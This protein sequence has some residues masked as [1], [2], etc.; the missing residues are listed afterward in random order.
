MSG[1]CSV[2]IL[3]PPSESKTSGGRHW[4]L[5]QLNKHSQVIYE[6][7]TSYHGDLTQ[8]YGV[9]DKALEAART[10]NK[11]ILTSPTLP[12]I[13]RY[14]GVV[15]DGL[16]HPSLSATAKDFF[17]GHVRIVSA[18]FGLLNADD[19]IPD[20]KLKIEKLD[21]AKYWKPV[22]TA[23]LKGSF[24]IDLLPRTHQKAVGYDDGAA[25]DFIVY[26]KSKMIPAGHQGKLI[27][28]RFVRWLCEHQ[29]TDPKDFSGFQEDGFKF[30]GRNFV[31]SF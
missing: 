15:Y 8:L 11:N 26:K 10:A 13:E 6:R 31:R 17:R 27:K 2:V 7:L 4:P 28:G 18:L 20:Y 5:G 24:V 29:V 19:L 1:K 25:V 30:D 21:A 14:S 22:I 9:K 12:V 16:D 23:D 3:I